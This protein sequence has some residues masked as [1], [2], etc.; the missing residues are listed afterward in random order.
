MKRFV[1]AVFLAFSLTA[2]ADESV[3]SICDIDKV[4]DKDWSA[5]MLGYQQDNYQKIFPIWLSMAEDGDPKYQ[6]YLA[7]AYSLGDGIDKDLKKSLYWYKQSSGQ[8]YPVAK[9]NLALMYENGQEVGQNFNKAFDLICNAA[10]Q[11][12]PVSQFNIGRYYQ[13]GV[14]T[15]KDIDYA[16]LWH[17]EAIKNGNLASIYHLGVIYFHGGNKVVKDDYKAFN[18]IK[19]AADSGLETSFYDIGLM[20]YN[21]WGTNKDIGKSINWFKKGADVGVVD[22][23]VMLSLIYRDSSSEFYDESKGL[24]YTKIS[25]NL[26]DVLSAEVLGGIYMFGI[27]GVE[28]DHKIS[29]YFYLKNAENGSI[30]S[31]KGL[32][33]LYSLGDVTIRNYEKAFYWA[34]K[35]SDAGSFSAKKILARLYSRGDGIVQNN[36]MAIKL[37]KELILSD[38]EDEKY[39]GA[40]GIATIY[41]FGIGNININLKESIKWL[42]KALGYNNSTKSKYINLENSIGKLYLSLG[43]FNNAKTWF[44]KDKN[45]NNSSSGKYLNYLN[46]L[47]N[48]QSLKEIAFIMTSKGNAKG[49]QYY[50]EAA[51]Q[52]NIGAQNELG[53]I[54]FHGSLVPQDYKV[55]LYWIRKA[56]QSGHPMAQNNLGVSYQNG[57]GVEVDIEEALH[58]YKLSAD[59]GNSLA[60]RNLG[61]IYST[62]KKD[63]KAAI[64]YYEKSADLGNADAMWSLSVIYRDGKGGIKADQERAFR[65]ALKAAEK[66]HKFAQFEVGMMYLKGTGVQRSSKKAAIWLTKAIDNNIEYRH[67]NPSLSEE[68]NENIGWWLGNLYAQGDGVD[69]DWNKAGMFKAVKHILLDSTAKAGSIQ[70]KLDIAVKYETEVKDYQ[71][72]LEWYLEAAKAGNV[73][74]QRKVGD[75]YSRA[76]YGIKKDFV[77][78]EKWYKKAIE[79]GDIDSSVSLAWMYISSETTPGVKN[80]IYKPEKGVEIFLESRKNGSIQ[81]ID[82]LVYVYRYG[83]GTDKD[84]DKSL[85]ML[86]E[87]ISK[88]QK[89]G[90]KTDKLFIEALEIHVENGVYEDDSLI[91]KGME[92]LI[93]YAKKGDTKNQLKL[94]KIYLNKGFKY[95]NKDDGLYWIKK[96]SDKSIA[97]NQYLAE[98]YFISQGGVYNH[99]KY[100]RSLKKAVGLFE[101]RSATDYTYYKDFYSAGLIWIYQS[102]ANYY[103]V[104][105][106]PE[107]AEINLRKASKYYTASKNNTYEI[108]HKLILASSSD[109]LESS[110]DFFSKFIENISK[111][112]VPKLN[113]VDYFYAAVINLHQKYR[114]EKK[115]KDA[116]EFLIE[117]MTKF[118]GDAKYYK[119]IITLEIARDYS[120]LQDYKSTEYYLQEYR[121][122][123]KYNTPGFFDDLLTSV[124][125][126]DRDIEKAKDMLESME[127]PIEKVLYGVLDGIVLI[128]NNN[129][130][131]GYERII[132]SLEKIKNSDIPIRARDLDF[133]VEPIEMLLKKGEYKKAALIIKNVISLYKD[134]VAIRADNNYKVSAKEKESISNAISEYIH[135]SNKANMGIKDKGF[136]VMQLSSGLT[137]SDSVI[138]TISRKQLSGTNYIKSKELSLLEEDRRSLIKEKFSILS[139]NQ[140]TVKIDKELDF[141]DTRITSLKGQ[142][143]SPKMEVVDLFISPLA[144][145]QGLMPKGDALITM[146]I[147]S[148][149][150][151]VWLVTNNGIFRHDSN[152]TKKDIREHS[153]KLLSALNPENETSTPFPFESSSELYDMLIRPFEK[154]LS[155]VDRLVISPDVVLSS[156]PFSILTKDIEMQKSN[157]NSK[158]EKTTRGIGSTHSVNTNNLGKTEWLINDYAIAT[159]PSV[160]SYIELEKENNKKAHNLESFAGIGNPIL[161]GDGSVLTRGVMFG[162]YDMRGNISRS[163]SS[164][165][166]LPET[167]GELKEIA[168]MF[169]KSKI[170]VGKDATE[171]NVN[172]MDLSKFNVISFAT[173]ALVSNQIDDLFEPSLVL[174]P[175]QEGNSEN[176]GLLTASE[177]SELDMNADIVLLSAC[178]TASSFGESNSQGLSGLANSFFQA[179]AKSLLVS[180]WSVISES[181]VDITTRMFKSSNKGRSYAHKHRGAVLDLLRETKDLS[182]LHPS[183]WSPFSVIGVN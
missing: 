132:L 76:Q 135:A 98:M 37:Y 60:M 97:A 115:Y 148:K 46:N 144:S 57:N 156:I 113:A 159:V 56:A 180:Y 32:A 2:H 31:Q 167:E 1:F 161:S 11:G 62:F 160:Y 22:S 179:G 168:S 21:G 101:S 110:K 20:Y 5:D 24:E 63:Y 34:K 25:A 95:Y 103:S 75:Y 173:H 140:P 52:G 131:S 41:E 28:K 50:E 174:T 170:L 13:H 145:V 38:N 155:D 79:S 36:N 91:S 111:A 102:L 92:L 166:P 130:D 66:L 154:Q 86:N 80:P 153:K 96:A 133:S 120:R 67:L 158:I 49:L 81:A 64:S 106:A 7:K 108:Q 68:I 94:G 124:F 29:E 150:S 175:I 53:E 83:I 177:V 61:S 8:N 33:D 93:S 55:A 30:K 143:Q 119:P 181:A 9:N 90:W 109:N 15:D 183:Y 100:G 107:L 71:K 122:M 77:V 70:D 176:D 164:L 47:N 10:I 139:L 35:A 58:W 114:D 69:R 43:D 152:L 19:Q 129:I 165:S 16:S 157:I 171:V 99:K 89:K 116:A 163:I 151:H 146:L 87:L 134:S 172:N 45:H 6:F 123:K 126:S 78:A 12:V 3:N 118:E 84:V 59:Q 128:N 44:E 162:D 149:R 72:A 137:L 142:I 40:T 147:G 182:K 48:H 65:L 54:Y 73:V 82:Y 169:D 136:E 51:N 39:M 14:G 178:N 26:G 121:D 17:Q 138:K 4:I 42:E 112:E 27:G 18:L 127:R 141:I 104:I 105:D 74:A 125:Y 117:I 85:K 88:Y 23:A